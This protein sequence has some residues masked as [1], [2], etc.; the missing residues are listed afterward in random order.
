M[1][2]GT[3]RGLGKNFHKVSGVC[4]LSF[5]SPWFVWWHCQ[6]IVNWILV[7]IT[8]HHNVCLDVIYIAIPRLMADFKMT[9][10]RL[11]LTLL[12]FSFLQRVTEVAFTHSRF[13]Q[14]IYILCIY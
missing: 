10:V 13:D 11:Y 14:T 12:Y 8:V 9:L 6:P 5:L 3:R 2:V 7:T 1:V 4:E